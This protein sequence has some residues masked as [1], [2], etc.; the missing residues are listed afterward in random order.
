MTHYKTAGEDPA[1]RLS[2]GRAEVGTPKYIANKMKARGLQR[3]RW[4]CQVCEKQ[5][6]D[7]NGFKCHTQ[8][9]SHLRNMMKVGENANKSI[10]NFSQQFLHDF[11]YLLRTSHGEKAVSANRFYNEYIGN[12]D[13]IHMN[14]TKWTSLTELVKHL[15]REHICKVNEDEKDGLTIAWIDNSAEALQRQETLRKKERL[16]K[17]EDYVKNKLLN[18]QI[19]NANR[20]NQTNNAEAEDSTSLDSEIKLDGDDRIAISMK[21]KSNHSN[22]PDNEPK[23]AIG[24]I[25]PLARPNQLL[26]TSR[27]GN[28]LSAGRIA[29][30][31]KA[32]AVS[33]VTKPSTDRT[34][35][36]LSALERIMLKEKS[37]HG[38]SRQ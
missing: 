35:K 38:Q 13:H 3:L 32:N 2:M 34:N 5:C 30:P 20:A 1:S 17:D 11:V 21:I 33:K 26:T 16:E 10:D 15:G 27:K 24:K 19:E 7:E 12:K 4:Y 36:P 31:L 22:I 9:P 37:R 8:S 25:N 18:Q 6:R 23:V 14:A 28:P 29:N